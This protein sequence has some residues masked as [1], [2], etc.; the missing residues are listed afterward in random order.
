MNFYWAGLIRIFAVFIKDLQIE[1][2]NRYSL[3]TVILFTLVS[4]TIVNFSIPTSFIE[5]PIY[6]GIL[7]IVIF[8]ASTTGMIRSFISE[9]EKGTVLLLRLL[10]NPYD[11]FF[12]KFVFN[13]FISFVVNITAI[14]LFLIFFDKIKINHFPLFVL[15]MLNS[16]ICIA[17][18]STII[19]AIVAKANVKGALFPILSLPIL[20]PVL[21]VGIEAT[22]FSIMGRSP[23]MVLQN[24][25]MIFGY[26][27]LLITLSSLMFEFVW[28]E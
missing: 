16:G 14:F 1:F 7:W 10:S 18:C 12:G 19:G 13:L 4:T 21:M 20:I 22:Q 9:E 6:A 3:T 27:G 8:F 11:V 24:N 2:K 5:R 25:V 26:T 15:T 17:G 23:G 28:K